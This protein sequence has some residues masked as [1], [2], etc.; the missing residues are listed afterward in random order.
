MRKITSS[1][2][3]LVC[4]A[5]GYRAWTTHVAQNSGPF[6]ALGIKNTSHTEID[7]KLNDLKISVA[8][9]KNGTKVREFAESIGFICKNEEFK[10]KILNNE[11]QLI[12]FNVV[13]SCSYYYG[14]F[15]EQISFYAYMDKN[16]KVLHIDAA[17]LYSEY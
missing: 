4:V 17:N 9:L 12:D 3:A 16:W 14:F 8:N 10:S 5:I 6:A 7:N 15:G 13:M 11:K 2:I 1:A